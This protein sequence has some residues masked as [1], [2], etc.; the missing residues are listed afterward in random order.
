[1]AAPTPT[2]GKPRLANILSSASRDAAYARLAD[3]PPVVRGS[4]LDG[5]DVWLV[6]GYDEIVTVL[7]DPRISNDLSGH[8]GLNLAF[9]SLPE[10][11]RPYLTST[12]AAYDPP[13][14]TRLRRV[15]SNAFTNRRINGLRPRIEEITADLLH[16][17]TER[18]RRDGS[19]DLVEHFAHQLP[20]RVIGELLGVP[21]EDQRHWRDL[22][23]G[24]TAPDR[25]RVI[26]NARG[27]VDYVS[28]LI[29]ARSTAAEPG[30]D[31]LSALLNVQQE[32]GDRLNEQEL[33]SLALSILLAGHRTTAALLR[34]AA[35]LLLSSPER[36]AVI[37]GSAEHAASAVEEV[38]RRYGPAEIGTLRIC[39]EPVRLGDVLLSRG[40]LVQVVLAGG[41]RDPRRFSDPEALDLTRRRNPHLGFGHGIHYCLGAALARAV[42]DIAFTRLARCADVL[43]LAPPADAHAALLDAGSAPLPV[44]HADF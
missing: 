5:S 42:G 9:T 23:E 41:N 28:G 38:L 2:P 20:I 1:M 17:L 27:L 4:Y 34:S 30:D 39:R 3:G 29:A 13:D 12:L 37:R 31:L 43:R 35:V 7:N 44:R 22:A 25:E 36:C 40:D 26:S 6:T 33:V 16:G 10:D 11:L 32:D 8:S 15:V 14:H 18:A 24:L 21:A 19:A